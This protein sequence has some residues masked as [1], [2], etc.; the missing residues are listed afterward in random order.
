M[1]KKDAITKMYLNNCGIDDADMHTLLG[2]IMQNKS[3]KCFE[4]A[5]NKLS[6]SG[7]SKLCELITDQNQ[8]KSL[9]LSRNKCTKPLTD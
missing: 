5:N 8:L 7:V 2:G 1:F 6:D 3:I 4:L 9:I